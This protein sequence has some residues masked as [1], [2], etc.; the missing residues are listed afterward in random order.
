VRGQ[1]FGEEKKEQKIDRE[2]KKRRIEL[3]NINKYM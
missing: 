1:I 2:R 3:K